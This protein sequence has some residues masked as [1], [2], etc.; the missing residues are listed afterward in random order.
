MKTFVSKTAPSPLV[1]QQLVPRGRL[2]AGINMSNGLLVSGRTEEGEPVGVS[3]DMACAVAHALGVSCD[4]VAYKTPGDVADALARDEWDIGLI[5]AEPQR[6]ATISFTPAY[7][8]IEANF[9]VRADSGLESLDDI[10]RSGHVIVTTA[11]AAFTLWLERHITHATLLLAESLDTARERFSAGDAKI[12]ASLK[13]K[14]EDDRIPQ[15]RIIEPAFMT[16]QQAIGCAK[17][18]AEASD[19]LAAWVRDACREDFVEQRI[20]YHRVK[21]LKAANF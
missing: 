11:R 7:A 10:D 20:A 1:R 16:V 13:T 6:A 3:P 19:W 2:R 4:L 17:A 9:C 8:L 5:G 14:I 12:L 15:T 21:G 18:N